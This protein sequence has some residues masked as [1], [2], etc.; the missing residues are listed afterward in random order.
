MGQM[1]SLL[2]VGKY[3]APRYRI[4][5]RNPKLGWMVVSTHYSRGAAEDH[6]AMVVRETERSVQVKLLEQDLTV[7]NASAVILSFTPAP[8]S[9]LP[10]EGDA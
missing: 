4:E 2:R 1:P 9:A 5:I 10:L 6:F 7:Q 3:E 8:Q